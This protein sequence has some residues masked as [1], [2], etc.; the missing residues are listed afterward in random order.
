MSEMNQSQSRSSQVPPPG[1]PDA[2]PYGQRKWVK[3]MNR[4][5]LVAA[6]LVAVMIFW[7]Q[8][9]IRGTAYKVSDKETLYYSGDAT[10]ADAKAVAEVLKQAGYF[11]GKEAAE[12]LFKKDAKEGRILSFMMPDG[13]WDNAEQQEGVKELGR[14]A[15]PAMGGKPVTVRIVDRQM[16]TK[17]E[18]KVE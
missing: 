5:I 10:E 6:I 14:L 7:G 9:L 16:N 15:A 8:H 2:V 4:T 18:M 12:V 17:K 1:A 13:A 3:V 11:N